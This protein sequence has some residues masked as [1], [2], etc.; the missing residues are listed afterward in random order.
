[1]DAE[2]SSSKTLLGL[3][4]GLSWTVGPSRMAW[5]VVEKVE[6]GQPECGI[7]LGQGQQH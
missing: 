3:R 1:M 4:S 7:S 6:W 5:D 2:V